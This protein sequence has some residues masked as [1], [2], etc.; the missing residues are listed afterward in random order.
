MEQ[1]TSW[2]ANDMLRYSRNT[3]RCMEQEGSLEYKSPLPVLTLS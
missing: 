3:P 2:E 1:N